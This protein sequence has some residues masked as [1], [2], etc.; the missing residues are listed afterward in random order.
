MT[1]PLSLTHPLGRWSPAAGLLL[2]ILATLAGCAGSGRDATG[3]PAPR[4]TGTFSDLFRDEPS[5]ELLGA[6][7][8]IVETG[9]GYQ[10]ALQLAQ[11][12]LSELMIVEV[13]L[14]AEIIRFRIPHREGFPSGFE[15]RVTRQGLVG[16]FL[17]PG[18]PAQFIVLKRGPSYWD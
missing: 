1:R 2:V 17:Y 15:G 8:R 11:G 12:E 3:A 6:E 16:H 18:R 4:V 13:E 9:R 7:I 10:G 5:G 14:D